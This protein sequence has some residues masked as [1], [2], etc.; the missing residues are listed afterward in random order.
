MRPGRL[1]WTE[2]RAGK[3]SGRAVLAEAWHARELVWY[4]AQR[5]LRVRY[6][7]AVL[8]VLW[9]IAQPLATVVVFTFVFGRL[10]N[11]DSGDVP[12]PLLTLSGV[13]LWAY[14]ASVVNQASDVLVRDSALITKV[15]FPRLTAPLASLLPPMAD[16]LVTLCL[17]ALLCVAYGFVPAGTVL[18]LPLVLVLLMATALGV[19]L[20]LSALNVRY[21]DIRHAILP[22]MQVLLFVSPVGYPSNLV[23]DGGQ[24]VY[25]LNPMAGVIDLGRWS[26]LGAPWPGWPLAVSVAVCAAVLASGLWYFS[27][28]ERGFADVI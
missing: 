4:F 6:K 12:Y 17:L 25:A 23:E 21:R 10:A 8:G 22:M 2:N 13:V 5:D 15:Y 20:W 16:M 26:L 1:E 18:V 3:R 9:A 11:V 7:Q 24:F 14:F 27:R 28:A 19:G